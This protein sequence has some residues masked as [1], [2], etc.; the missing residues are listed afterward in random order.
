MELGD[1]RSIEGR[2]PRDGDR[3][4]HPHLIAQYGRVHVPRIQH[5]LSSTI[6]SGTELPDDVMA[7][8]GIVGDGTTLDELVEPMPSPSAARRHAV[9]AVERVRTPLAAVDDPRR[10]PGRP[11]SPSTSPSGDHSGSRP[12]GDHPEPSFAR[13]YAWIRGLL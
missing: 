8:G 10:C 9:R 4:D 12:P 6:R 1:G 13:I 5:Q 11:T 3:L 2:P 7:A